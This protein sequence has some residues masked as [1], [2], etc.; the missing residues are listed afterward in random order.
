MK[1]DKDGDIFFAIRVMFL[2][3]FYYCTIYCNILLLYNNSKKVSQFLH[4]KKNLPYEVNAYTDA[5]KQR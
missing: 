5:Q 1:F 2:Y 4:F 3:N